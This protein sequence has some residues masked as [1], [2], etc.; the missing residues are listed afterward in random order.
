[1]YFAAVN[2]KPAPD[3]I[4]DPFNFYV[5]IDQTPGQSVAWTIDPFIKNRGKKPPLEVL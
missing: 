3:N 4:N 2:P 1:V 5:Q